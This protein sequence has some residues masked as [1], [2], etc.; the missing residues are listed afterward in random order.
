M[1]V[2]LCFTLLSAGP[3]L[4][5]ETD[6]QQWIPLFNGK[7]LEGWTPKFKGYV[8]GENPYYIFR[9]ENG[10]LKVS[11]EDTGKFDGAFGHLFYQVPFSHYRLRS[12]FRFT[13][14]QAAGGPQWSFMNNGFMIHSQRPESMDIDQSFPTSI[15]VQLY[16]SDATHQRTMGNICTPQTHVVV[17]GELITKHVIP[18]DSGNCPGDQW[19]TI[20]VEV[21]GSDRIV[22]RVNGQDV[23]Q[24]EKPQ[25]DDGTLLEGG[26]IAIQAETHPTEFRTIELLPLEGNRT[27]SH[28]G[29]GPAMS[30]NQP[31][32]GYRA[33]FDGTSLTGW[34]LHPK[35]RG[36]WK[37][38]DGVIDYDALS[39]A[40]GRHKSLWTEE[41]FGDFELHVEWRLK[42]TEG[43]YPMQIILPDG[44]PKRDADG[45]V[46]IE[47][48]PNADSG[49]LLRGE[50]DS[51]VNIWCWPVG[52]G[53]VWGY[54]T[55]SNMPDEVR[56]AATPKVRADNPVGQWNTFVITMKRDRLTVVLNGQTVIE[57]AQLPGVPEAGPIGLQH[58]GG[59]GKDGRMN[60]ASSLVQFRNIFIREL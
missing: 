60:P 49:I 15:E 5:A 46:I 8:L 36:H 54:R 13:G 4:A 10:I 59:K 30:M 26:H 52:S 42:R 48:R 29:K 16:G 53:E 25:L 56:K 3:T 40:P 11:Y 2:Y 31:P 32:E 47:K 35:S 18:S 39:E 38:V 20:E 57:N 24:Y 37:V 21:H 19:T 45:K 55:N 50:I 7:D 1:I 27:I 14:Q 34:K 17:D 22:H 58:H 23:I 12:E 28:D 6:G 33:L 44:S 43:L 9:V 51:Q 41:S